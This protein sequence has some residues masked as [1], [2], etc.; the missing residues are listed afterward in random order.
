MSFLGS[1]GPPN[2]P[3]APTDPPMVQGGQKWLKCTCTSP[4]LII[5]DKKTTFG[6]MNILTYF[7]TRNVPHVMTHT[8]VKPHQCSQCGYSS[9]RLEKMRLH[10]MTHSGIKPHKCSQC[11][12]SSIT[13]GHMTMHMRRA[14][15]EEKPYQCD[16]CSHSFVQASELQSHK[17][18]HTEEKTFQCNDCRKTFKHKKSLTTHGR[19]HMS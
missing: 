2:P 7:F 19:K 15:T 17:I 8:G 9:T 14:H 4:V 1:A 10:E 5:N 3:Q 6:G 16:Q 13:T 12:F 11:D 18:S